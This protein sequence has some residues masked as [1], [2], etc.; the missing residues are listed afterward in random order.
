MG[1]RYKKDPKIVEKGVNWIYVAKDRR[2]GGFL[3]T[4]WWLR[5]RQKGCKL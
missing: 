5:I 4:Q 2:H 3:W 1:R